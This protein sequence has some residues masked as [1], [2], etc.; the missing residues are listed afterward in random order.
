MTYFD[1]S[2]QTQTENDMKTPQFKIYKEGT[3]DRM[4]TIVSDSGTPFD[5]ESKINFYIS[6]GYEVFDLND[7][8]LTGPHS[9]VITFQNTIRK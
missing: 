6:L 7:A 9:G 2:I 3:T 1:S 4:V 8:R 5:K